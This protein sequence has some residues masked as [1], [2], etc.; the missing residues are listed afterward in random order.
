MCFAPAQV[1]GGQHEFSYWDLGQRRPKGAIVQVTLS[2]GAAN[3]RLFDGSN[4]RAFKAGR[5][6]KGYGGLA[7]RSPVRLEVPRSGHWYVVVDCGDLAGRTRASVEVLPGLLPTLRQRPAPR[8]DQLRDSV[9]ASGYDEFE[10]CIG[11]SLRRKIDQGIANSRFGVVVLSNAFFAK[12]WPQHELDG[13]VTRNVE[14]GQFLLPLWHKITKTEVMAM[15]P[16][17]ADKL[18]RS[19]TDFT[20]DEIAAE[21]A[22]VVNEATNQLA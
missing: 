5:K 3:V 8:L 14:G 10:V 16:T 22:D 13:L 6:A 20:L 12:N 11:Q 9:A 17:L 21:I 15:S 18:A 1:S 7:K 19:T 2:G 4:Y